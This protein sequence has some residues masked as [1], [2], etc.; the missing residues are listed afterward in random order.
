MRYHTFLN[1]LFVVLQTTTVSNAQVWE[2]HSSLTRVQTTAPTRG[3]TGRTVM[4]D[5]CQHRVWISAGNRLFVVAID[6]DSLVPVLMPPGYGQHTRVELHWLE[7]QPAVSW[8]N[9]LGEHELAVWQ[10]VDQTWRRITPVASVNAL[11]GTDGST[12]CL[13]VDLQRSRSYVYRTNENRWVDFDSIVSKA[14]EGITQI[15]ATDSGYIF[16]TPTSW[17]KY[18]VG[19]NILSPL[20]AV[21][22]TNMVSHAPGGGVIASI[23][24]TALRAGGYP[25]L[26]AKAPEEDSWTTIDS[27]VCTNNG[28][29]IVAKDSNSP[30]EV[31]AMLTSHATLWVVFTNGITLV[32]R[33]SM[34]SFQYAGSFPCRIEPGLHRFSLSGDAGEITGVPC[35]Q[36]LSLSAH[37]TGGSVAQR[38]PLLGISAFVANG[39]S[40]VATTQ[41]AVVASRDGVAWRVIVP[42]NAYVGAEA[43]PWNGFHRTHADRIHADKANTVIAG[44]IEGGALYRL[45]T[46][47]GVVP[48]TMEPA[49]HRRVLNPSLLAS[50]Q[51]PF[52]RILDGYAYGASQGSFVRTSLSDGATETIFDSQDGNLLR[53]ACVVRD[54][55][56]LIQTDSL[57]I[58]TDGGQTWRSISSNLP[59]NQAGQTATIASMH[60]TSAEIMTVGLRGLSFVND[61]GEAIL[62]SPGGVYRTENGGSS[63]LQISPNEF[64]NRSIVSIQGK[65]SGLLVWSIRITATDEYWTEFV[66]D[67]TELY[68]YDSAASSWTRVFHENRY[69]PAF[70]GSMSIIKLNSGVFVSATSEHGVIH[71]ADNGQSWSMLGDLPFSQSEIYDVA[72][73]PNGT[74]YASTKGEILQCKYFST[75]V[76]ETDQDVKGKRFFTVWTYPTPAVGSATIRLSNPDMLLEG[77]RSVRLFDQMG[78]VCRDFTT[79][80][81]G[82][83]RSSRFEATVDVAGLPNGIYV[84]AVDTGSSIRISKMLVSR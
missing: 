66:Q 78:R 45:S 65:D 21:P 14:R 38:S 12:T 80:F 70:P 28:L 26:V 20:F 2:P 51:H 48:I 23:R 5:T 53:F 3:S 52:V 82:S 30:M 62:L 59:T 74:L 46:D 72:L 7:C 34:K 43:N 76:D 81:D 29:R 60:S 9:G 69:R 49:Y 1:A 27:I 50:I 67:S 8:V 15:I 13:F 31:A 71:S 33:D 54:S 10:L 22:S 44:C 11:T 24:G 56:Y 4:L 32:T 68:L 39:S 41:T 64:L 42:S 16:Q 55:V 73:D 77:V 63:W 18:N 47:G 75:S 57:R 79:L 19:S 37:D 40:I 61:S 17:Y 58:T 35:G 36:V 6:T 83:T 25:C 84:I